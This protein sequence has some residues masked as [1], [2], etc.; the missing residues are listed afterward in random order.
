MNVISSKE[1]RE[2][3]INFFAAR[4]HM[5]YPS[6]PISIES[7]K[8]LLFVN[9]GMCQFKDIF[10]GKLALGSELRKL[11]RVA[12]SQKC[13]RA[14]GKHNDLEDVGKDVYH[15][16]FFEMLGNW[17]FRDYFKEKAI[18][19]A[20]E[21][22]TQEFGIKPERLYVTYFEGDEKQ[23]LKPDLETK[24]IWLKYLPEDHIIPG[25]AADNFWEMGDVGPCGPCTEIH[26]DRIGDRNAANLVNKDDPN[27]LEIWNLVFMQMNREANGQLTELPG[28]CV[29]TGMG[30][31][32]L[33]SILNNVTSNYDTDLFI[34]IFEKIFSL[35]SNLAHKY[36]GAI[37]DE[38]NAEID[39]AY[40]IVADHMRAVVVAISDGV[41]PS[42][43]GRGYVIRRIL[44]RAVYAGQKLSN[45][46]VPWLYELVDTISD[47][48][49]CAFPN[50]I[51]TK[52]NICKIVLEEETQFIKTLSIGLK[53]FNNS[54][55]KLNNCKSPPV[56]TLSSTT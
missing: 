18:C 31:E 6:S 27:V 9:A 30:L 22:F 50:L 5:F 16:T 44:R 35:C 20:W 53:L 46:N 21:C 34:P 41:L 3:F 7:D 2:K 25:S 23:N 32:R 49:G 54:V 47:I 48:L 4:E 19:L 28:R 26:Y 14:G 17:S 45:S 13:I 52:D 8:T 38:K 39:I 10:L 55:D 12:N 29:D 42:N 15:H 56:M 37:G 43:E 11:K 1:C 36:S 40:R 24:Q 51:K 33:L